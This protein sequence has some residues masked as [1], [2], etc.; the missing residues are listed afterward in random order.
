MYGKRH[1]ISG[2]LLNATQDCHDIHVLYKWIETFDHHCISHRLSH[3]GEADKHR[4][5]MCI[6]S[7]W[8]S[9]KT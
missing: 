3:H 5:L 1:D 4:A 7:Q 6:D 9:C 2:I 8:D